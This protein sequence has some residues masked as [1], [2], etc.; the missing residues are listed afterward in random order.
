MT[1]PE[2]T[3]NGS[4]PRPIRV[5]LSFLTLIT[6]TA[7]AVIPTLQLFEVIT[8]TAEQTGT[9]QF[10]IGTFTAGATGVILAFQTNFKPLTVA[11]KLVGIVPAEA[12]VTPLT[13]PM[14]DEGT[15]LV[16]TGGDGLDDEPAD[17]DDP[18]THPD[19]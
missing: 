11:Q 4:R 3:T 12:A 2:T 8:W 9:V 18:E 14:G 1:E 5:A 7:L 10:L 17:A 19:F 15:I 13:D 16:P 6:G